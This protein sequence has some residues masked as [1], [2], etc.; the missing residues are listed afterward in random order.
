METEKLTFAKTGENTYEAVHVTTSDHDVLQATLPDG[1]GMSVFARVPGQP[2]K[3]A[4]GSASSIGTREVL[5]ELAVPQGIE[6]IVECSRKGAENVSAVI[7][8]GE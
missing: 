1:V 7:G 4:I 6:I 5:C 2:G 8:K 3:S